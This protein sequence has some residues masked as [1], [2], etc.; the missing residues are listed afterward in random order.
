[1]T[2]NFVFDTNNIVVQ[3]M[4]IELENKIEAGD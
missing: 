4:C 1:M 2:S 3:K